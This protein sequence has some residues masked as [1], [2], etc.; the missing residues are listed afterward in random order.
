MSKHAVSSRVVGIE[1]YGTLSFEEA[2][3]DIM[4]PKAR[5]CL[6]DMTNRVGV[7]ERYRTTSRIYAIRN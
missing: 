2:S 4:C 3:I 5:Q 6:D 7:I 1:F